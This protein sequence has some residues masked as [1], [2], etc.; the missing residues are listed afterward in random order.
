MASKPQDGM[1]ILPNQG[2][3]GSRGG[4][5][6]S[7]G[8]GS[9]G[10]D[11]NN[12]GGS[13]NNK[14]PRK[15]DPD[16]DEMLRQAQDRFKNTF[17]GKKPSTEFDPGKAIFLLLA[18]V[19]VW[20]LS[21]GFY[22]VEPQEHA[23]ILTFG[24]LTDTKTDAGLGYHLPYP[25]QDDIKVPVARNQRLD[26]GFTPSSGGR[27]DVAHE[28]TMLTG[29]ANI[30]NIHFSVLW[31]IG[32][33]GKYTF[34]IYDP[35]NTVKKVAE[36]AMREIIGR[37]EIQKAMTEGR[38]EIEIKTKDLMQR[39]LDKYMQRDEKD[40]TEG[41]IINSVQ[42]LSVDPPTP[43]VVDAFNDVQR[44]RTDKDRAKNEAETY[45]NDIVPRAKGDAQ[46][47]IQDAQAYKEA[48]IAHAQGDAERFNSVYA[49]YAQSKDV[50]QR[51]IYIETMQEIM[52][53]SHKI[54]LGDDKAP[55]LPLLQLD[56]TARLQAP[57]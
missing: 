38:G 33:A 26:V 11:N 14:P 55:V 34:D 9:G 4:G 52:K 19:V 39:V 53:N 45:Q 25:V 54:I 35:E 6:G 41:I 37:T 57:Q 1:M 31:H 40:K 17:G 23:L 22:Q 28:S 49:A 42:L 7:G 27:S 16:L 30:V 12:Q 2:P 13:W 3:W 15:D 50:T 5:Q 29:D 43:A 48:V 8:G 47:I 24:K 20:W 21:T 36:S 10:G 46:K 44:A 56:K 32:D 51:R 18:I